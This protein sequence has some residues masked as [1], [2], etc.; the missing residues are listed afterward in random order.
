M[1]MHSQARQHEEDSMRKVYL[2]GI[3]GSAM[4]ALAGALRDAGYDVCGSDSG[5]YS[6][7]KEFLELKGIP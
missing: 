3:G 2:L 1:V 7:M 5:V 6:P 4:G